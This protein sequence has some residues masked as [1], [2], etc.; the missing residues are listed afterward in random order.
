MK[1]LITLVNYNSTELLLKCL[2]SIESHEIQSEYH[3]LVVDNNS[4]DAAVE[5][6]RERFPEITIIA[7]STNYGYAIAVNQAIQRYESDFILLLNPD[8]EVKPG[9]IDQLVK[10][11]ET[12]SDVGIVG[13]KL[14]NP[15]GSLQYSCRTY[16]TLPVILHR[17]TF[18]KK[19]F[20]NSRAVR[21]HLML[22]WDHDSIRDVDWVLGACMMIRRS[23]LKDVGLM[24]ERFFLYFEDVDWCYRM[25]KSGWRVCY[26]P[27]AHMMHHHRRE[28]AQGFNRTFFYLLLSMVHFYD[29]WGQILHFFKKYRLFLSFLILLG[30]DLLSINISFTSAYFV[31]KSFLAFLEKPQL[32]FLYYRESLWFTNI[33]MPLVFYFL[34][35]YTVKRAELWVDELF[36]V[37]KGVAVSSLFFMASSY[38]TQG[39]EFSRAMTLVFAALS[40]IVMFSLRWSILSWY[41]SF[42]KRGFNLR[43]T[44]IVGTGRLAKAVQQEL[45][46]HKEVG[47]DIVGFVHTT[48]EE[49]PVKE[50]ELFPVLGNAKDIPKLIRTQNVTEIIIASAADSRELI[51]QCKQDGVNV[52]LIT[53]LYNLSMHETT[54][55]EVAGIPMVYF[56]GK[57]LFPLKLAA[58]RALD[59][60][61]SIVGI[62]LSSPLMLL[63][64]VLTKL[65]APSA[66]VIIKS[67]RLGRSARPFTLYK[68]R[69]LKTFAPPQQPETEPEFTRLGKFLRKYRLDLLPQFMN[70]LKGDMSLVGPRPLEASHRASLFNDEMKRRF[71]FRPGITGLWQLTRHGATSFIEMFQIDTYYIWNWS[72]SNDIK[73]LLRSI[74]VIFSGRKSQTNF[75][76]TSSSKDI[77]HMNL[78]KLF[79][80]KSFLL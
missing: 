27:D 15:D 18:L 38:L 64:A 65:E 41:N 9:A 54:L 63:I 56:Q 69:Y 57:P 66:P 12:T 1:V 53:N 58:K 67:Q 46:A 49:D 55:E 28:S 60:S 45:Q 48:P 73:I 29:K 19:L 35:L 72:L 70:V 62:L 24:D 76:E 44:L 3:V 71:E 23:A 2:H 47:F 51:S 79:K 36:R 52:R 17:R 32:P 37:M 42:K 80:Q 4:K 30:V 16:F 40:V 6:V 50:E 31:R 33:V 61:L 39:Y 34:G 20:P 68:F 22:D 14:L 26:L 5:V 21:E 7:N 74:P 78:E 8:I 75:T 25:K 13:G 11:M 59:L 43:R 10:F 77:A